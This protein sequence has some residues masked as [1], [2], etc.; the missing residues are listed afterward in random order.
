M[1]G[2]FFQTAIQCTNNTGR[3]LLTQGL[4]YHELFGGSEQQWFWLGIS[5]RWLNIQKN[6]Q[7]WMALKRTFPEFSFLRQFLTF[8][9]RH[10]AP[11]SDCLCEQVLDEQLPAMFDEIERKEGKEVELFAEE[12]RIPA[13]LRDVPI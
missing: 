7:P 5:G 12:P 6:L 1:D 10:I 4:R 8:P 3:L 13:E 11:L 9:Q 2:N